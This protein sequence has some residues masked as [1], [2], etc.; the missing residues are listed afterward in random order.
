MKDKK[1]LKYLIIVFV[2]IVLTIIGIILTINA[3]KQKLSD[4]NEKIKHELEYLD[5]TTLYM[6]ND[7]NNLNNLNSV[8]VEQMS[9]GSSSSNS[10]SGEDNY[11]SSDESQT[12]SRS[13]NSESKESKSYE[14]QDNSIMVINKNQIDWEN[15]N[16]QAEDLYDS[17]INI[18]IDLNSANVSNENIL[19]FSDNLDNLLVCLNNQDKTNSLICLANLYSLIPK[20]MSETSLDQNA[21]SLESVKSNI[22][23]AYSLVTSG[24]WNEIN[25]F[26]TKAEAEYDTLM[27]LTYNLDEVKRA[28]FNRCYVLLKEL[29]KTSN[30]KDENL[31]YLKYINL[32]NEFEEISF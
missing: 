5:T 26:L 27:N 7:L 29:I 9:V 13:S 31:F 22:I 20:Y 12:S 19:T 28:K 2:A 11:S 18:T 23:S 21:I 24:N 16:A 15:I 4:F 6:I 17:W 3:N 1:W 25:T 10:E 30:A 8:K 32:M 14:I